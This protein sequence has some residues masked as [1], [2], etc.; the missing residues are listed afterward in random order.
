MLPQCLEWVTLLDANIVVLFSCLFF[1]WSSFIY[2]LVALFFLALSL[3]LCFIPLT[4]SFVSAHTLNLSLWFSNINF[5]T[6]IQT[7]TKLIRISMQQNTPQVHAYYGCLSSIPMCTS[8]AALIRIM[9]RV[10]REQQKNE[11][12][13]HNT[14]SSSSTIQVICGALQISSMF[15][16]LFIIRIACHMWKIGFIFPHA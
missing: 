8:F 6:F 16:F 15:T 10:E 3:S 11:K 4:H 13:A 12:K 2:V 1:Y 9:W 14:H 7:I 5:I